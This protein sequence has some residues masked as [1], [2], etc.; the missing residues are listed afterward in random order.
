MTRGQREAR[1]AARGL[2][3][4]AT[5]QSDGGSFS[6]AIWSSSIA[7]NSAAVMPLKSRNLCSSSLQESR[8]NWLTEIPRLLA[9]SRH[10]SYSSCG[11]RMDVSGVGK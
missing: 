7:E 4:D 3:A 8:M 11:T 1:S 5:N 2:V 6:A 9:F 10:L